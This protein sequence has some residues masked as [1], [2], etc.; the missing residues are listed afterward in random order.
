MSRKMYPD[1]ISMHYFMKAY[2]IQVELEASK[3]WGAPLGRLVYL[4]FEL[5]KVLALAHFWAQI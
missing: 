1:Q 4:E 3:T 5:D 2:K